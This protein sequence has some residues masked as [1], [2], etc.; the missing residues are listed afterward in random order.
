MPR[1]TRSTGSLQ[2]AC[3][4]PIESFYGDPSDDA[5]L[6]A[7]PALAERRLDMGVPAS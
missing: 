4:V 1:W 2:P 5:L 7:L 3:G 6:D